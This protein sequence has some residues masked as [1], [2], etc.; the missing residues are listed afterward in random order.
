MADDQTRQQKQPDERPLDVTQ[1]AEDLMGDTYGMS[2]ITRG[3]SKQTSAEPDEVPKDD[4]TVQGG[5]II[6]NPKT[7]PS[8]GLTREEVSE[9]EYNKQ[10]AQNMSATRAAINNDLGS[11]PGESSPVS[12]H[13]APT[14]P[15][16][17]GDDSAGNGK[18]INTTQAPNNQP[19]NIGEQQAAGGTTSSPGTDDDVGV[20]ASQAGFQYSGKDGYE[21]EEVNTA[22]KIDEAEESLRTH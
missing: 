14:P 20:M 10:T 1:N 13:P 9:K 8:T 22:K 7:T 18:Y 2:G 17:A 19:E 4:S 6:K 5:S 3:G 21:N 12:V 11:E 15:P 16:T